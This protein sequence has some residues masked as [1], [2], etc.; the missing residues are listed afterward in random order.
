MITSTQNSALM[1]IY[2]DYQNHLNIVPANPGVKYLATFNGNKGRPIHRWFPFKEGFSADLFDWLHDRFLPKVEMIRLLDP[3]CGVGTSMLSAQLSL[4]C[5]SLE[6]VGVER[7]PFIHFV[8][9][10]KL[11]WPYYKPEVLR[12]IMAELLKPLAANYTHIPV[13]ALTTLNNPMAFNAEVLQTMLRYRIVILNKF[14]QYKEVNLFLLAW[15]ACVE[16]VSGTR[17]DGR[18]LRFVQREIAPSDVPQI[19]LRQMDLIFAD[20]VYMENLAPDRTRC[21]VFNGDSRQLSSFL[22]NGYFNVVVY[23]PPYLNNIDYSEV[24]KMELWLN[25]FIQDSESFRN[26]RRS[27]FR[28]HPSIRFSDPSVTDNLDQRSPLRAFRDVILSS[29]AASNKTNTTRLLIKGYVDDL[30]I[31]MSEQY[32]V[33]TPAAVVVCVIGNSMHGHKDSLLLVATDLLVAKV[34]EEVGFKIDTIQ[35][36]RQLRRRDGSLQNSSSFL[37]ESIVVLRKG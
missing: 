25:E 4:P 21:Q 30:Y 27:T 26:L 1:D 20:L 22:P 28:S 11:G 8:A 32:K 15:S 6:C 7:N 12:D 13:P 10:T 3:F 17:K 33:T 16:K 31:A 29:I 36:T 34:A 9:D 19:L 24:Y 35:V 37:R 23:S 14:R 2:E 5:A 18:A